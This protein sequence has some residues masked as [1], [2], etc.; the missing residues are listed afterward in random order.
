MAG[1]GLRQLH[2]LD[3]NR[4]CRYGDNMHWNNCHRIKDDGA[5]LKHNIAVCSFLRQFKWF[6][7]M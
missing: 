6:N 2:S 3:T 5:V 7:G 1:E 4:K